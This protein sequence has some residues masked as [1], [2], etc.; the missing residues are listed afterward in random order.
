MSDQT[1]LQRV[2]SEPPELASALTVPA[3][4]VEQ[5]SG[6]VS[7]LEYWRILRKRRSTVLSILLL[8]VLT[9][10]IGT[11]K[12]V[13]VF[14]ARAVLQIDR[15]NPNLFS[16]KE[17]FALDTTSD[18]YLETAYKVLESE[19][20]VSRVIDKLQLDRLPQFT[21]EPA[22][23]RRI[24][25][26]WGTRTWNNP[27]VHA[28]DAKYENVIENFMGRLSI[29]PVR[30]SRL[31]NISFDS[32][33]PV[34][35]AQIVN[36]M[37]SDYIEQNFEAKWDATQKAS[38]WLSQQL[39]GLKAKL[40][41]SEEE[42]QRYAKNNSILFLDEKQS[43]G[44]QKLK[45]LQDD[46]T[47]A[48]T[49]LI[50]KQSLYNQVKGG[51]FSSVPGILENKLYQD[52]SLKLAD[53]RRE[54]S[55]QSAIF[56]PEYP[57][58]KRLKAQID[59]TERNLQRQRSAFAQRVTDDY[60]AAASRKQLLDQAVVQQTKEFNGIAEKSIQYNILKRESDTN[61]QLYD[62]LLERVKEA[63]V[64]AGMRASNIRIV[65]KGRIPTLPA[66]PRILIN[67]ALSLFFGLGLGVAMA[68]FQEYLDNTL[69]TPEDVQRFL[70][71]PALGVIPAANSNGKKKLVYGYGY[72]KQKT[73]PAAVSDASNEGGMSPELIGGNGNASLSE[74]YRSLRT[75][76]LLSTSGRP[77]RV[78]LIT[79]GQ[80]GEGK[81]TTVVN[82][83]IALA[84]LGGRVVVIDSDMRRPRIASILKIPPTSAGL[85]T[86]L[87][88]QCTV[89]EVLV[90]TQIPNLYVIPCGP[91]PP[92]PAE[93]LS[94]PPMQELLQELQNL[95]KY[96][97]L[98]SPPVLHVSDAQILATQV[99]AVVLVAHGAATPRELVDRG[100][101][102]LLRVNANVIGVV[103]NNL[104]LST[105]GYEHYYRYY[106][107]YGY[108]DGYGEGYGYGQD[109]HA[110][111]PQRT[112]GA[113]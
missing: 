89:A 46:A 8:V 61:R 100:K 50:D 29:E 79:S 70:H 37:A 39:V 91:I 82:L 77:P 25:D 22:W 24:W 78:L 90:E 110:D 60:R 23:Y 88:G 64:S 106:R 101:E 71:L 111:P 13:P 1:L 55:E 16:F 65:D 5:E 99:E 49:D 84:Q 27:N 75:S 72:G 10:M 62:G 92:N 51:D 6:N 32:P 31:V 86:L 38:E 67:F 83:A 85:S 40:E 105:V 95:F 2:A 19:N 102:N 96:V 57:K 41:T 7:L 109:Q 3:Y 56:N 58:V 47:K 53:L 68:F 98:D 26:L 4:T 113:E 9:V 20:L 18:D 11:L 103:L 54:Y 35:A 112:V 15:E 74:A 42:L 80:P 14:R 69:K 48:Q 33:D 12:Q 34:L 81:T 28:G 66:K 108:G 76:V 73:L 87:T 59:E 36:T 43:M 30:R 45:Q 63:S 94:S 21:A 104:D 52:L 44:A 17:I 93:L 107:R 97:L